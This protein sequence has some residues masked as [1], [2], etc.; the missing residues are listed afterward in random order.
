MDRELAQANGAATMSPR[1]KR[2]PELQTIPEPTRA[3]SPSPLVVSNSNMT[4]DVHI[5]WC[6]CC[7]G[8]LVIL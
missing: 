5:F 8:D 6:H 4:D 3:K 2:S 7:K 1:P